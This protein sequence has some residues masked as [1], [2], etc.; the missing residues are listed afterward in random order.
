MTLKA[1]AHF[2]QTTLR[3]SFSLRGFGMHTGSEG[4]VTVKP[5]PG[6]SGIVFMT[7]GARIPARAEFVVN[8]LRCTCIEREGAR[9]DTVEHVLSA[10][11][12]MQVD[13]AEIEVDGPELPVLD[14][15]ALPWAN[16]IAVAGIEELAAPCKVIELSKPLALNQGDSWIVAEPADSFSV[17]AVTHYDHPLL[18]TQV[19]SFKADPE[20]YLREVAPARTYGFAHEVEA[21]LKAGLARGGSLDNALVIYDDHFSDALRVPNECL[22]HKIVDLWGDLALAGGRLNVAITAIKPG[23][24]INTAFAALLRQTGDGE[25]GK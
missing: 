12:G 2:Q 3:E 16:A 8:T 1:G 22:R 5:A 24:R 4:R 14:G 15:S 19:A 20:V 25:M 17:T 23:H 10:L 18:G 13:N 6:G 9:L 11:H 7:G 21:L